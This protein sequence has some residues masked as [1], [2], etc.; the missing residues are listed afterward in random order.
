M[1]IPFYAKG[2][3]NEGYIKNLEVLAYEDLDG[4]SF[5]QP[6]LWGTGDRRYYL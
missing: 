4:A 1:A 3:G 6:A 2:P 5:F